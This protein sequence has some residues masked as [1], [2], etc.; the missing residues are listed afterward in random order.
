MIVNFYA[1][2]HKQVYTAIFHRL[3][4]HRPC[5]LWPRRRRRP[6]P[7]RRPRSS[8]F[9]RALNAW[10]RE[11]MRIWREEDRWPTL[12]EQGLV[13]QE[14]FNQRSRLLGDRKASILMPFVL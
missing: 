3:L 12:A 11:A 9:G 1:H 4:P 14:Q 8:P 7:T 5:R 2:V 6:L 10:E 13:L